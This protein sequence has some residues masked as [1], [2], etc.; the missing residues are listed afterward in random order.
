M[1]RRQRIMVIGVIALLVFGLFTRIGPWFLDP[2]LSGDK[3]LAK[4]RKQ[5][6]QISARV[7]AQ[8]KLRTRYRDLAKRS[9]SLDPTEA[10]IELNA[11]LQGVAESAKLDRPAINKALPRNF[12]DKRTGARVTVVK[13]RV[14]GQG[15]VQ[16]VVN[17][18]GEFYRLPYLV[19][20]RQVSLTPS[21]AKKGMTMKLEVDVETLVLQ[22]NPLMGSGPVETAD[23]NPQTRPKAERLAR[24]AVKA[25]DLIGTKNIFMPIVPPVAKK[26]DP[27]KPSRGTPK[28]QTPRAKK[29]AGNVVIVG[30]TRYPWRDMSTG[31]EYLIQEVLTRD[32]RKEDLL[33]RAGE[34]LGVGELVYVDSTGAVVRTTKQ[35]LYF[36]PL[37]KSLEE[38]ERLDPTLHPEK[39]YAVKQQEQSGAQ[40]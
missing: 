39:Y 16:D 40:R 11:Q 32:N 8:D 14:S 27:K 13:V 7:D 23:L 3:E 36:Y 2:I 25:Y 6:K 10:G 37:G 18:M 17:F 38:Y 12:K 26:V 15:S 5:Y 35:E 24:K 33:F 30:V 4:Y 29:G 20:I 28:G 9:F 19:Q 22:T 21:W 1:E 34:Q 31:K